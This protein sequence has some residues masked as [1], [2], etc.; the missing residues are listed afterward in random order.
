MHELGIAMEIAELSLSRAGDQRISRVVVEV[1]ALTAVLPDAL[2]FA[3]DSVVE[4]TDLEGAALEIVT[5]EGRGRCR[6][7]ASEHAMR[8]PFGR[9][10]CGAELDIVAGEQLRIRHLEVAPPTSESRSVGA[11]LG[12]EG[13]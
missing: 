1:G 10:P 11:R 8:M 12:E 6:S 3:W 13:M 4:A 5:I 9:C 7:C 2:A